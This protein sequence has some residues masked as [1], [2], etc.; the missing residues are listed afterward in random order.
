MH[1]QHVGDGDP[2]RDWREVARRIVGKLPVQG[3]V[4][5]DRTDH[6][7]H[8]RVGDGA[9]VARIRNQDAPAVALAAAAK[10]LGVKTADTPLFSLKAPAQAIAGEV[11]VINRAFLVKANELGG[12]VE[13]ARG[14]YLLKLKEKLGM[15]LIT[16][17]DL[18]ERIVGEL[19]EW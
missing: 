14:I 13:T 7:Q 17:K 15:K 19:K 9:R 16:I 5:R 2:L 18:V 3:D 11:E 4:D 6:A 8:Q 12:P 10:A 1:G